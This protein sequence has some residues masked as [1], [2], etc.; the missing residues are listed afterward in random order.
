MPISLSELQANVRSQKTLI[1]GLYGGVDFDQVPER[2]TRDLGVKSMLAEPFA[3][4]YR[5]KVLADAGAVDRM[6]AY[7]MLGDTVADAYAALLPTY[8]FRGLV[9]MLSLACEKGLDA[10]Q[11]PP[12]ELVRFIESMERRPDWIDPKLSAQGA[13]ATR[14]TMAILAPFVI[15][16]AFIATF[17]NK[18]SGLPMALTGALSEDSAVQRVKET[19]SF[20]TTAC[21]PNALDRFGSGFRA[22]AMVRLMHSMVRA[23]LLMRAGRWDS[24]V[25]GIPIPQVDQMPAGTMPA[26][27]TAYQAVREKRGFTKR[28][29]AIVELCRHQ[30]FL[31]GLPDDLLLETPKDIF[32]AMLVY[33]ATLRDGYDDATNGELVRATMAAYLP[34]ERNLPGRVFDTVE[35]SVSKVFFRHTF[36]VPDDKLTQMQVIPSRVDYAVF[37]AFQGFAVPTLFAHMAA[38]RV[39]LVERAAD[40]WLVQR[41]DELLVSYGHAEYTTNPTQHAVARGDGGRPSGHENA[42]GHAPAGAMRPAVA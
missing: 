18:Y 19:A 5:A 17:M 11:D 3:T 16:G 30:C 38:E 26:F 28:E 34:S 14:V 13:R 22:A 25:F 32:E 36:R 35:R 2:F 39:P 8:G 12:A 29:R 21:L 6:Q 7:T 42:H 9:D 23:S 33:S 15:R 27:V 37:A 40:R 20:F 10:V 31:L 1:P 41:L 24:T 4:K